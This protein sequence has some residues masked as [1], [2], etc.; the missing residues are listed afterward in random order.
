[1]II[2]PHYPRHIYIPISL[3][4]PEVLVKY[5]KPAGSALRSLREKVKAKGYE[6]G[7]YLRSTMNADVPKK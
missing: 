2:G 7:K 1:M 3:S 4:E 5:G 6:H